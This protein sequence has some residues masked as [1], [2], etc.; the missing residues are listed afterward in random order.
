MGPSTAGGG[1]D[2][3]F[4]TSR[5][6]EA[7]GRFLSPGTICPRDMAGDEASGGGGEWGGGQEN[8]E[9]GLPGRG[10]P[11]GGGGG[12]EAWPRGWDLEAQEGSPRVPP[13]SR[14]EAWAGRAGDGEVGASET[15][16][17]AAQ[18]LSRV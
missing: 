14:D 17:A 12:R 16:A 1:L 11:E 2:P 18:V 3:S 13:D 5:S 6:E 7:R 9:A 15:R 8:G 4:C 10:W